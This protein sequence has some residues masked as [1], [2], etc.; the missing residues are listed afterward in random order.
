MQRAQAKHALGGKGVLVPGGHRPGLTEAAA[1]TGAPWKTLFCKK[2]VPPPVQASLPLFLISLTGGGRGW[3]RVKSHCRSTYS[4]KMPWRA[5]L[6]TSQ[7][8]LPF[9]LLGQVSLRETAVLAARISPLVK[10]L[11]TRL[12]PGHLPLWGRQPPS[13]REVSSQSDDGGSF[14]TKQI[15]IHHKSVGRTPHEDHPDGGAYGPVHGQ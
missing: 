1:E 3:V 4:V 10:P 5:F 13:M 14:F 8:S 7:V 6:R 12:S 11:P 9:N 2:E 15:F